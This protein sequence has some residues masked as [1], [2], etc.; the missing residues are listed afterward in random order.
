MSAVHLHTEWK[1]PIYGFYDEDIQ[2][3]IIDNRKAI[4]FQC[5]ARGCGKT[6]QRFHDTH[7]RSSSGNLHKHTRLCWGE[8]AVGQA[9]AIGDA[10][11]VRS[12]IVQGLQK[13][14]DITEYFRLE[15]AA[16]KP[17]YLH[18]QMSRAQTR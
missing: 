2:L 15:K 14:S 9:K 3:V 8:E 16:K 1:S 6:L 7:D 12:C 13:N 10:T 4:L 18:Q 17:L 11:R 5:A